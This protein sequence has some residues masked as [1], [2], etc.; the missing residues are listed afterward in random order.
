M[1]RHVVEVVRP[2]VLNAVCV[3]TQAR[4]DN[5]IGLARR[6]SLNSALSDPGAAM[7]W[8]GLHVKTVTRSRDVAWS[9]FTSPPCSFGCVFT[10]IRTSPQLEHCPTPAIK[11]CSVVAPLRQANSCPSDASPSS[12]CPPG[13]SFVEPESSDSGEGG[14]SCLSKATYSRFRQ[15]PERLYAVRMQILPLD[16]LF[17]HFVLYLLCSKLYS[18]G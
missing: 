12:T 13:R 8:I 1:T 11:S 18:A 4:P 7:T 14:L 16:I 6:I 17:R 9:S 3:D 15:A 5:D 2:H 10:R